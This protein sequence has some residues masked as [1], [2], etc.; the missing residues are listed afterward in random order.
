MKPSLAIGVAL[1]L[2]FIPSLSDVYRHKNIYCLSILVSVVA[3]ILLLTM[4]LSVVAIAML[5]LIGATWPGRCIVGTAYILEFFP[6]LRQKQQLFI[7]LLINIISIAPLPFSFMIMKREYFL[8]QVFSAA[9]GF[10]SFA[11]CILLMPDSPWAN[12]KKG[13]SSRPG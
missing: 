6:Q 9:M 4:N 1:S 13:T 3:Q 10:A 8:V 11:Y 7:L 12:Y 5:F 2:F